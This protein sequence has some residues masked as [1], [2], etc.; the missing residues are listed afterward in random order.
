MRLNN[1]SGLRLLLLLLLRDT[2]AMRRVDIA[3]TMARLTGQALPDAAGLD[4]SD[5]VGELVDNR[6]AGAQRWRW[7]VLP[8]DASTGSQSQKLESGVLSKPVRP[9]QGIESTVKSAVAS[10]QQGSVVVA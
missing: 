6:T 3:A 10:K 2:E 7:S 4:S 5:V 1:F 9:S 8:V